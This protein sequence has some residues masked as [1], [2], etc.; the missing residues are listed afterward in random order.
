MPASVIKAS[1]IPRATVS[2]KIQNKHDKTKEIVDKLT[3]EVDKKGNEIVA[4]PIGI[5]KIKDNINL[6]VQTRVSVNNQILYHS[7]KNNIKSLGS[8]PILL[9]QTNSVKKGIS[10]KTDSAGVGKKTSKTRKDVSK[11]LQNEILKYD[12]V[13]RQL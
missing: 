10:L 3:A 1:S 2:K 5:C 11:A 13:L 9:V 12:Y 8:N 6:A 4:Q 7:V